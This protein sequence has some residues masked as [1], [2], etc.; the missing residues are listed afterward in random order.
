MPS[1]PLRKSKSGVPAAERLLR[2]LARSRGEAV[3]AAASAAG[4][5]ALVASLLAADLLARRDHGALLVTAAGDAY[6][7]RAA[8]A[9]SAGAPDPFLAQ[10][11]AAAR[12]LLNLPEGP[13]EVMLNE[14]ESPLTWLAKRKGRDGRP[15]IS[16]VQFQAGERL[17]AHFTAAALTPRI[18]ANWSAAVA[19]ER[20]DG[21]VAHVTDAAVAARQRVR[22]AVEAVGPQLAGVLLDVCCFLKGLDEVERERRWPARSA[23]V[24]LQLGLDQLARH[25]GLQAEARG[26]DSAALRAWTA[27][28]QAPAAAMVAE[29]G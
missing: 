22:Q 21:G 2:A 11:I 4:N 13:A 29:G 3:P 19:H 5:A 25:Y 16:S 14:A 24:V 7:A 26:R 17:R 1:H 20:R 27:P 28:D 6:L 8:A 18:T 23:K 9:R 15:L 12:C 10:H